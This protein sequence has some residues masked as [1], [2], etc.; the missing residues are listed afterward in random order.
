MASSQPPP[1]QHKHG[2]S[3][4]GQGCTDAR[5][6]GR[7]LRAD[8]LR[9]AGAAHLAPGLGAAQLLLSAQPGAPAPPGVPPPIVSAFG[10]WA[11]GP[12]ANPILLTPR[13]P[14]HVPSE[15]A[16]WGPTNI[17]GSKHSPQQAESVRTTVLEETATQTQQQGLCDRLRTVG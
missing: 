9:A 12:V 1:P 3:G 13:F 16:C 10:G 2:A 15:L 14:S 5:S 7:E 6:L 11:V 8:S 17:A 4:R